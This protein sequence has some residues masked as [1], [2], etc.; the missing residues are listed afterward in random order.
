MGK[1]RKTS[2]GAATVARRRAPA[3]TGNGRS[4]T[5][6]RAAAAS[7]DTTGDQQ[8]V[9]GCVP[10]SRTA[11]DLPD[12]T[13]PAHPVRVYA[14]GI[15]DMFHFGH[16]RA[17]EQA[18]K[19]FPHTTLLVGCC[20][21]AM[22]HTLK[23]QTVFKDTERYESLRHCKWVDEVIEDAPWVVT[24]EFLDAHDI[25]YVAHDALPYS[26]ASGQANDVY[27]FVKKMGRFKETQRTDGISTSDIILRIVRN[28]NDYVLRNLKRGY[29]RKDL[30][31]SYLKEQRIRAS[32]DIKKL[33]KKLKEQHLRVADRVK[34]NVADARVIPTRLTRRATEF[35]R[36]C[37]ATLNSVWT[38]EFGLQLGRNM[39][40]TLNTMYRS[41]KTAIEGSIIPMAQ[42]EDVLE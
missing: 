7:D 12:G 42:L 17:L 19:L 2:N 18:K 24:Q 8:R 34:K 3:G 4:K 40:A 11:A 41:L 25:H 16:A 38:G 37:E 21:D 6:V 27:D 14:D 33:G 1:A 28:Y 13:D 26:D 5:G 9:G 32:S 23:G 29:S 20:S 36:N 31:V 10:A 30:G 35:S 15:F 39:E 22:T